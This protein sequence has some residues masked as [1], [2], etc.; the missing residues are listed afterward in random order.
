MEI[1]I[2]RY[3]RTSKAIE[4]RLTIDNSYICD[5]EEWPENR[6]RPGTYPLGLLKCKQY[7]RQMPMIMPNV[8]KFKVCMK[9]GTCAA[10]ESCKQI[11]LVYNNTLL[12]NVCPML[13]PGN[14]V[15]GRK[16]GSIIVGQ[17]VCPGCLA[18]PVEAFD[19]L[20]NLI[21]KA[22]DDEEITLQIVE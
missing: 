7:D 13:K 3:H 2:T 4:G 6:L 5:T 9:C 1:I 21:R 15:Y 18:H 20:M 16:D 10:A 14:G 12:H 11:R 22:P 17:M 19:R 8:R